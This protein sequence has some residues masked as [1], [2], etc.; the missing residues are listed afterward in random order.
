MNDKYDQNNLKV[1]YCWYKIF[2]AS[3]CLGT[4][5][6]KNLYQQYMIYRCYLSLAIS[7]K[8]PA[9]AQKTTIKKA[10]QYSLWCFLMQQV[11]NKY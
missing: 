11:L 7:K 1:Q 2:A 4:A 10:P 5:S 6:K 8:H 3:V 9:E